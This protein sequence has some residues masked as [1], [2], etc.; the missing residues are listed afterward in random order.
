MISMTPKVSLKL[1]LGSRV[2]NWIIFLL[3][4]LF[5]FFFYF[6]SFTLGSTLFSLLFSWTEASENPGRLSDAVHGEGSLSVSQG[7]GGSCL[8]LCSRASMRVLPS[9]TEFY[10]V[11]EA[12]FKERNGWR[13]TSSSPFPRLSFLLRSQSG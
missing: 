10:L 9:F 13:C 7:K 2:S 4:V 5:L 12:V 11:T 6:F 1:I 8:A 3:D